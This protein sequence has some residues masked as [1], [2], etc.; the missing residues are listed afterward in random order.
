MN[1]SSDMTVQE[2]ES[3]LFSFCNFMTRKTFDNNDWSKS[4]NF[5]NKELI[6]AQKLVS[7]SQSLNQL[8]ISEILNKLLDNQTF[9]SAKKFKLNSDR[10][11][12]V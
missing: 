7:S 8:S 1:R 9:L 11:S 5:M 10:K 4:I 12:V 2:F 6:Q 3:F